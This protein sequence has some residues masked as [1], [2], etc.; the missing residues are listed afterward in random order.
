MSEL[1]TTL[2]QRAGRSLDS[3]QIEKLSGYIDLL[4]EANKTMNL[5]RIAD[6][7]AA[8]LQHVGDSLTLLPYL[9]AGPFRI[10]DVGTGGGVP[11]I[12]LAIALPQAEMILIEATQ[13]KAA[14]L[15]KTVAAL[16]LTNVT[17]RADRAEDA[18]R[19]KLRGQCDVVVARAVAALSW[20]AEWCLPL[21]KVGG[22]LLAMK[23]QRAAEELP[24][25]RKAISVLGGGET[26]T[27]PV[28][29]PGADNLVIIQIRKDKVTDMKY[30]RPPSIAKGNAIM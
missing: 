17:V 27:H 4:L 10:A 28:E 16:G 18:G 14:F 12:P 8:E 21:V 30:P 3:S 15:E 5:T 7:S 23:G 6:R 24:Q 9:P 19:S 29:L 22:S 1:W 2:A 26:V 25:A 11:G 20:L 13:K